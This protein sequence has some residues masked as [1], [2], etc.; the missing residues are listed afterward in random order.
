[1]ESDVIVVKQ[2]ME[3]VQLLESLLENE[4]LEKSIQ[5]RGSIK[6]LVTSHPFVDC[7]SRLE[8]VKGEPIWGLS[9]D[10]RELVAEAR[11]KMNQS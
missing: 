9:M 1:M 3:E 10:E 2:I 8:C 7:L 5:T 11:N 6:K 4:S